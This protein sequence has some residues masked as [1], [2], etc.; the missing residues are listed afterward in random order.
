MTD[1]NNP[2]EGTVEATGDD[3]KRAPVD[4]LADI[5]DDPDDPDTEGD[6]AHA[7]EGD[8]AEAAP[9]GEDDADQPDA[10]DSDED[11]ASDSDDEPEDTG[12]RFVGHNARVKL[13]DGTTATVKELMD[14]NL[15][16]SAFTRK[17][18]DLA[19]TR[20]RYEGLEQRV[21]QTAQ[22]L[23][24]KL[25]LVESMLEQWKPQ[26]PEDQDDYAGWIQYQQQQQ[27]HQQWMD[28]LSGHR[29]E[30]RKKAEADQ[31]EK[32][33][34]HLKEQSNLFVQKI[35]A[36]ADQVKQDAFFNEAYKFMDAKYGL[37]QQE[38]SAITDH[39]F[40]VAVRDLMRADR[41]AAALP[42]T[43]EQV[44]TKPKMLKGSKRGSMDQN[45]RKARDARADRL[46]ETGRP[47]DAVASLMDLDL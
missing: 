9:D 20:K 47:A 16:Q 21:G 22:E 1:N 7:E 29:D 11:E 2:V 42:K 30:L 41:R 40:W 23:G 6:Q 3:D 39:R 34:E 44:A 4:V 32:L 13:P 26:P 31:K 12:G 5:L 17:T 14:G 27:L 38:L 36:M 35:P 10:E 43:R 24:Q 8:D 15:R 28:N 25:E 18:Q 33:A 37:S 46:R 45:Q 19:E